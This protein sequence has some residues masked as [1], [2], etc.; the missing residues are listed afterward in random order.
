MKLLYCFLFLAFISCNQHQQKAIPNPEPEIPKALE[1]KKG[2]DFTIVSKSRYRNDL[3]EELYDELLQKNTQLQGLETEIKKIATS[4]KDSL[5][6]FETYV[7]KNTQYY[8]HANNYLQSLKDTVLRKKIEQILFTSNERLEKNIAGH[9]AIVQQ[10]E[11]KTTQ[12]SDLHSVLKVVTTLAIMEQYQKQHLPTAKPLQK[13]LMEY[14][15]LV[16]ITD[17]LINK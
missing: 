5:E 9:K 11:N 10:I 6:G 4:K 14:T 15:T 1:D 17:S 2:T 13:I 3:V 8:Q 16:V 7:E 12:L